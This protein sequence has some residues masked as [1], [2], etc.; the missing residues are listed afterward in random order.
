[1]AVAAR[2]PE[3][4]GDEMRKGPAIGAAVVAAIVAIGAYVW[5]YEMREIRLCRDVRTFHAE[6]GRPPLTLDEL[7]DS[8]H[9]FLSPDGNR[10]RYGCS[11]DP[12]E[13]SL[14]WTLGPNHSAGRNCGLRDPSSLT[15]WF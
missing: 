14:S 4:E 5:T 2:E 11:G 12:V 8:V 9:L 15:N 13:C 10:Y 3:N 6:H 1:L 7:P